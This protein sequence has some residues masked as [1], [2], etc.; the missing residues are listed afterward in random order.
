MQQNTAIQFRF[1]FRGFSGFRKEFS[2]CFP[3]VS[4][5]VI[6]FGSESEVFVSWLLLCLFDE[7]VDDDGVGVLERDW[8]ERKRKEHDDYN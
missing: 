6:T 8:R 1:K 3:V 7:V 5:G 2:F 4:F